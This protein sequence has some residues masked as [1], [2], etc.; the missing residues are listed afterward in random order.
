MLK[1][2]AAALF[3][4]YLSYLVP[5][6]HLMRHKLYP[7]IKPYRH[8][9]LDVGDGHSLYYELCGNPKGKPVLFLHGGP[10]AGCSDN[11]R[12][13]FNPKAWNIILF[14]QRGAGRSRPFCSTK[15]NT[16]WKLVSDVRQLLQFLDV[17]KAF[18][19][20]GSWGSTLALVYAIKHPETVTG[21]AL[22]GVF[23]GREK[24]I[25]YTYGGGVRDFFPDAWERFSGRVPQSLRN[26]KRGVIDHYVRMMQSRNKKT[27]NKYAFEFAHYELSLLKLRMPEKAVRK[28][29]KEFRYKSMGVIESYYM[30]R[31][32]F[33]PEGYILK[34]IGRIRKL[35]PV[36]IVQ[37]RYDVICPPYQ[38]WEL[39]RALPKSRLFLVTAGHGSSEKETQ[40]K[41]VEEMKRFR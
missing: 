19:F 35:K 34:N 1:L 9:Y 27:A 10:G 22:R 8:G 31:N 41:L 37:G 38:A 15:A 6:M 5:G 2:V 20:G 30:K 33:L 13:Y 23:L 7:K 24:D 29:L 12:R 18:L 32:C 26:K 4:K 39:H 40:G 11:N 25:L 36:S 16:T 17:K 3:K 14:D 28:A 21:M